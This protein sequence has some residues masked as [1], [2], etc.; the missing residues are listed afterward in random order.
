MNAPRPDESASGGEGSVEGNGD[1]PSPFAFFR[2]G[3]DGSYVPM[4]YAKSAWSDGLV[5]GPAI[6]AA[7][8]R[9]LEIEY[10]HEDF[11][12]SRLTVDLFSQVKFEPLQVRTEEVRNGNRIR[13]A[14]AHL[15]QG[16]KTVAR[17]T[18]VQLRRG[19][20]PP[21]DVWR[22]GRT[23][24]PPDG[25]GGTVL[26]AGSRAWFGS[27]ASDEPWSR[28]MGA[29]QN[30]GRKRFW[31]HPLDVVAGQEAS[32][33]QRAVTLG[34]STSLMAHWGTEGIG[35]INAD[36]T[37]AL[38]RLPRSGDIGI[39]AEQHISE[40][41]VAVG[42]AALFDH[43]GMFGSG[44]VVAVSNAGRQIDFATR[45]LVKDKPAADPGPEKGTRV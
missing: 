35:F 12:P 1:D 36:L 37:V 45:G 17:A 21:G 38:A 30:A 11:Q 28:S 6:V 25:P 31:L 43:D 40:D 3:Q 42:T 9:S 34:E 13:V 33:F 15:S 29:H 41:G 16:G 23:L 32:P 2:L 26:S 44:T 20:Q 19:E 22:S 39:E 14:D 7:A 4:R 8:A 10:G 24:T 5:N 18:L 27:D